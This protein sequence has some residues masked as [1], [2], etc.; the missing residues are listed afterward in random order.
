MLSIIYHFINNLYL[1]ISCFR[2]DVHKG[3]VFYEAYYYPEK[4]TFHKRRSVEEREENVPERV[5]QMIP[6]K[7]NVIISI[8]ENEVI[9]ISDKMTRMPFRSVGVRSGTNFQDQLRLMK[10]TLNSEYENYRNKHKTNKENNESSNHNSKKVDEE[11]EAAKRKFVKEYSVPPRF[12]R[13]T[14]PSYARSLGSN[15]MYSQNKVPL[16]VK[17]ADDLTQ[18]QNSEFDNRDSANFEYDNQGNSNLGSDNRESVNFG[19]EN[20]RSLNLESN[21]RRN[22]NVEF[23]MKENENLES[24]TENIFEPRPQVIKYLFSPPRGNESGEKKSNFINGDA[25]VDA[26]IKEP[27]ITSIE[28]SEEP[29]HKIR[30]HHGERPRRNYSR[31]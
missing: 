31:Q 6:N 28:V 8:D 12:V 17:F 9:V 23:N 14:N 27:G 22:A 3:P 30:H 4:Q 5:S 21:N 19:S 25:Q 15:F 20:E 1:Q 29:R 2:Y 26:V 10:D 13:Y 24:E 16:N 11:L 7:P 18:S